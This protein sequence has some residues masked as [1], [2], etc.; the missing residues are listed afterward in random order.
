MVGENILCGKLCGIDFL[1]HF[2]EF[3]IGLLTGICGAVCGG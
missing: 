1:N 2:G 3:P